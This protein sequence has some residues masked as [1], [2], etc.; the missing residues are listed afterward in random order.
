MHS[1]SNLWWL[2]VTDKLHFV[3]CPELLVFPVSSTRSR[4]RE[5][6]IKPK[7]Q[8][9]ILVNILNFTLSRGT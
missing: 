3:V 6:Q 5:E 8:G 2:S 9:S 7:Q 4:G 1:L